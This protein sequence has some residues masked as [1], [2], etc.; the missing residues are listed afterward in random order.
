[1]SLTTLGAVG[2]KNAELCGSEI[3]L[4]KWEALTCALTFTQRRFSFRTADAPLFRKRFGLECAFWGFWADVL[5]TEHERVS[6]S[7]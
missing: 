5:K 7:G 1:M 4:N 2:L 6:R 3:C